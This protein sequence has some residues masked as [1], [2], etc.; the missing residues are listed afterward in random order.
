MRK[1]LGAVGAV[2]ALTYFFDPNSGARRRAM[3]RDRTLALFRRGART[4][5]QAGSAVAAEAYGVSQQIQHREEE[6]K[7]QL[8]DVTLARKVESEIFRDA[9]VPKGN[10]NVNAEYGV[11]YLRGEVESPDLIKDLEEQARKVQGVYDVKNLLHTPGTPA[12]MNE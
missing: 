7:G 11:V 1:L 10:I 5:E 9:D 4:T 6:D 12:P 8:D 3:L 2:A